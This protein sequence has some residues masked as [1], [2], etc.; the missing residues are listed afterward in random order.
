MN[1]NTEV[2]RPLMRNSV[3]E[4]LDVLKSAMATDPD[5]AWSWQCNIAMAMFDELGPLV[6][7]SGLSHEVCNR[8]AARFMKLCFDVDV[9]K[10]SQ[11]DFPLSKNHQ[12]IPQNDN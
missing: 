3:S 1:A 10:F 8:A 11:W 2:P 12:R 7:P 5:Y 9:T 6:T 4:A